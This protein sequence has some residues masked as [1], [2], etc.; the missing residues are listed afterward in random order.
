VATQIER[1][2]A[3]GASVRTGETV[4]RVTAEATSVTVVTDAATYSA[5]RVIV[6]AGAWVPKL[7]G[8]AYA[9]V[10]R[11]YPQTLY[12][13]APDD[14]ATFAPGRFPI[15]IWRHGA[16]VDDHFY[17]FQSSARA[18]SWPRNSS[19]KRSTPMRSARCQRRPTRRG[20]TRRRCAGAFW[21]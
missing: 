1:A 5:A 11:V 16:G 18:S 4:T 3:V 12:W 8:G 19:H 10:L 6:T 15:F 7:L 17:G 14:A 21:V 20:C 2:R 9:K 13:F